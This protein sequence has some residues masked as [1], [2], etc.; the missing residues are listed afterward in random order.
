MSGKMNKKYDENSSE[1]ASAQMQTDGEEKTPTED[2]DT[3]VRSISTMERTSGFTGAPVDANG[4]ML[5]EMRTLLQASKNDAKMKGVAFQKIR[6][7]DTNTHRKDPQRSLFGTSYT[8]KYDVN[9]N[10]TIVDRNSTIS[11]AS[12]FTHGFPWANDLAKIPIPKLSKTNPASIIDFQRKYRTY[13]RG[14]HELEERYTSYIPVRTV[15]SC[16]EP[17]ALHYLCYMTELIPKQYRTDPKRIDRGIVQE[18]IMNFVPTNALDFTMQLD[19]ELNKIHIKLWPDGLESIEEA[20]NKL[21]ELDIKYKTIELKPKKTIRILASNLWPKE[22][23]KILIASM[24]TG[25]QRDQRMATDLMLFHKRLV[26]IA[27]AIK[28]VSCHMELTL[29][30]GTTSQPHNPKAFVGQPNKSTSKTKKR[31]AAAIAEGGCKHHGPGSYHGTSECYIEHPE[32]SPH[33]PFNVE[34]AKKRA[35]EL[36]KKYADEKKARQESAKA[37]MVTNQ[38]QQTS[39]FFDDKNNGGTAL[40]ATQSQETEYPGIPDNDYTPSVFYTSMCDC[41]YIQF[42]TECKPCEDQSDGQTDEKVFDD[43]EVQEPEKMQIPTKSKGSNSIYVYDLIHDDCKQKGHQLTT[44]RHQQCGFYPTGYKTIDNRNM[45]WD[46]GASHSITSNVSDL[47]DTSAPPF[48]KIKGLS[49]ASSAVAAIGSLNRID[50]VLAV[51]MSKQ[52]ILSVGSFLDQKGGEITFTSNEVFYKP[53]HPRTMI[54]TKIGERRE[55]GLYTA[56]D[57]ASHI[58]SPAI[59]LSR[60]EQDF[61]LTRERVHMLHRMLGHV[62]KPKMKTVLAKCSLLGLKPHHVDLMTYCEACKVGSAK[63]KKK[64]KKSDNKAKRFGQRLMSDNSGK[65]RTRSTNGSY[66]ACVVVDEYS[67]WIWLKGLHSVSRTCYFLQH[68]IEVELHQRND[69]KIE[70][71]RSDNGTEYI[72][73]AVTTLLAKHGIK[74]ERT[75]PGSSFQNGKAE[76][77][78]GIIFAMMRKALYESRLPPTFWLEALRWATYTYNRLPLSHRKDEKSPYEL[79]YKKRPDIM[80]L[81]PFGVRGSVTL[82]APNR[83]GKHQPTGHPC[84]MVGY[85]YVDGQK[86]YRLYIPSKKI[87]VPSIHGTFDSIYN[88]VNHRKQG[89]SELYMDDTQRY[90]IS[91]IFK[92]E[93]IFNESDQR[94]IVV[95]NNTSSSTN[96]DSD[97]S[98]EGGSNNNESYKFSVRYPKHRL[99]FKDNNEECADED[100]EE[101]QQILKSPSHDSESHNGDTK[102]I[103]PTFPLESDRAD[104]ADDTADE[105]TTIH[106]EN[107][108]AKKI[109]HVDP[110]QPLPKGWIAIDEDHPYL[111]RDEDG[112]PKD[113]T[114]EIEGETI[115]D[116]VR[117]RKSQYTTNEHPDYM[118]GVVLVSTKMKDLVSHHVT[119]KHYGEAMR[120]VDSNEWKIAIQQELQSIAKMNCYQVID[121]KD[122]PKNANVIGYQWVFKI[123]KNGDGT[124]S[125]YKARIC[126][127]GSKQKYGIDFLEVF[128][129]VANQVTIRLILAIAVHHDL[130]IFQ[131]DIKLAFVS[132]DIDRP[133]FMK[134]P[135]GAKQTPNK[136]WK[137]LKSLYG[138]KQAPRLFNAHLNKVL[139]KMQ[140]IQ[141]QHDPC[142]YIYKKNKTYTLLV[143]V[144]DDILL[145]TNDVKHAS[146]FESEMQKIFDLKSMGTPKYMIG[147]NLKRSKNKLQISQTEYIRD[148]A[149]RFEVTSD[150]PTSLPASSSTRLLSTGINNQKESPPTNEKNYRSLV[151][152]LMY[153]ILT[154]P[155]V[156]TPVSMAARFLGSPRQAHLIFA[157]KILR[158]LHTTKDLKLTYTKSQKPTLICYADSSFADDVET[159]RSRYGFM[160]YYG[161]ALISWKS[162]LGG[163]IKLSTAEAEYVSAL[164]ATKEIMWL[165]NLLKEL[166]LEQK[167]PVTIH[168]DNQACIKMAENPIVSGRNK[169]M[170][171]KMHYVRE[172]VREKDVKLKYIATKQQLAD[173]LTKNLPS[174]LFCPIRDSILDPGLHIPLGMH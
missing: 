68:V 118:G 82:T 110:S 141:S 73:A 42:P 114:A 89:N 55:D 31:S 126:V 91:Q 29:S 98:I 138:L 76:R 93:E 121:I 24:S 144:V 100:S 59:N 78:I 57:A 164:E 137:L 171:T 65:L 7:E 115:A 30:K 160:I 131:F 108:V 152:A 83:S 67:S 150:A 128:S 74:R 149:H 132:S 49:G 155:D 159:C 4:I 34:K 154:R 64:P 54:P 97:L 169:H 12:G 102:P 70:F 96:I 122:L 8:P 15:Y 16:I 142:L 37:N 11:Q 50:G 27:N 167:E 139:Q 166:H 127:N 123:K 87:V 161:N 157:T 48:K 147:M 51:P 170:A 146:H 173:I 35:K 134:I 113:E 33:Q 58:P 117:N 101:V 72:N 62:G 99:T 130:E 23:A 52:N 22:T 75:C 38:Q 125:R 133:V 63:F 14:V 85:G 140:F 44:H 79:R 104:A 46:S 136:V 6:N 56:S 1:K 60:S 41:D 148:M 120:S 145:A 9:G 3:P 116:R 40:I 77:T 10:Q 39:Q 109:S 17:K 80:H 94:P 47:N 165:K 5:Q 45:I 36:R 88:S 124:V 129:P 168:E 25:T 95:T 90:A 103:T 107:Q 53:S 153:A 151:G 105:N 158:Y 111:N 19:E 66:Y 32:L 119:P 2:I 28:L 162:K 86:G 18:I 106:K 43:D 21:F 143:I 84:I 69:H 172:R 81:R 112:R 163:G 26:E 174:H 135:K 20:W 156:A 71:F 92:D 13:L 61:Q